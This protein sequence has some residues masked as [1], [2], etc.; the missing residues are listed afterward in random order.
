MG[1]ILRGILVH[2]NDSILAHGQV[3]IDR[4]VWEKMVSWLEEKF[5]PCFYSELKKA[6]LKKMPLQLP[7]EC[8][9]LLEVPD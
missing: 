4:L 5:L 1:K 9:W 3:P 8:E 6:G 7:Q 2:R